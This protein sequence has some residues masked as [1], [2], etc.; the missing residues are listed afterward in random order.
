MEWLQDNAIYV[1]PACVLAWLGVKALLAKIA[2]K[3]ANPYDDKL[4]ELMEKV[5]KEEVA[6][7]LAAR[8]AK[9]SV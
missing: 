3:T 6:A 7:W 4:L 8:L 9:K 1:I 5:G 2:P